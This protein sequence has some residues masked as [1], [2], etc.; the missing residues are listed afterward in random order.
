MAVDDLVKQ[1]GS[2]H[3]SLT[4]SPLDIL[5]T[6]DRVR[7]PKAG[8]IVMF[9]GTTRDNFKGKA[10]Q[11]LTYTSYPPLALKTLFGIAKD[12]HERH[13]LVGIAIVH[14]LGIVPIGEDSILIFVSAPHRQAAWEA[15]EETLERCKS[16]VEIWKQEDFADGGVWR[17]NDNAVKLTGNETG[18]R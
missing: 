13:G 3:I 6:M 5:G 14:R 7:S 12:C 17:A 11:S 2:I 18:Q 16:M 1:E 10:V 9:A 8:A 15:G 4:N